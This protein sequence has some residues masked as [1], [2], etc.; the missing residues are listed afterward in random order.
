MS[1]RWQMNRMG[2]VN[3]WLYDEETFPFANG[4]LFLRGANASGKSI[5]TQSFIPFILDGDR[6]PERLDPFGS[7][8]RKMEYYFLGNDDKDDVTG[9]LFLEFKKGDTEQY[10]TIGIGQRAQ[11]GKPM[12]FWG[13]II[14]D[15]KRIEYDMNLYQ[16][17]GSK[18]IPYTK[19]DLKKI[20]G[21]DNIVLDSQTEYM[22]RVNKYIFGFPRIEQYDQFIR[23][24]IKVRAPKLSRDFKPTKVYEILNE[25]LQ[26]LSDE[27]LRAMVDA[28]E[29]MDDIQGRL[30]SLKAA[31]KDLQS[32]RT[33]YDH[34]NRYMLSKKAHTYLE[35]KKQVDVSR[36]K[37]D[38]YKDEVNTAQGDKAAK[39]HENEQLINN[40]EILENEKEVLNAND[41]ESSVEKLTRRKKEKEGF[42]KDLKDLECKIEEHRN[43]IREYY[44]NQRNYKNAVENHQYEIDKMIQELQEINEILHFPQNNILKDMIMQDD[45]RYEFTCVKNELK[46]YAVAIEKGFKALQEAAKVDDIW[47]KLEEELSTL[48]F[49]KNKSEDQLKTAEIME[50]Q[51]RDSIVEDF[52]ILSGKYQELVIAKQELDMIISCVMKYEGAKDLGEIKKIID[53]IHKSKSGK[54]LESQIECKKNREDL[55]YLNKNAI[56][57]LDKLRNMKDPIPERRDKVTKARKI[58]LEKG[59]NC[60]PFYEAVEFNDQLIDEEKS[61]LEEQLLDAGLLDALVVANKDYEKA[62]TEL[63]YLSDTLWQMDT[64]I[65]TGFNKL[66]PGELDEELRVCVEQILDSISEEHISSV[67]LI[68]RADGYFKN[69][70]IEGHSVVEGQASF[71][72][73]IARRQKMLRLIEEKEVECKRLGDDL[74]DCDLKLENIQN[75]IKVLEKE[76]DKIPQFDDLDQAIGMVQESNYILAKAYEE[77]KKMEKELVGIADRKKSCEQSVIISCKG[78]PFERK[79]EDYQGA[80]DTAENYR[81]QLIEFES[82]IGYLRTSKS[83]YNNIQDLI[84]K[85]EDAIDDKDLQLKKA[86]QVLIVCKTEIIQIEEF[87]SSPENKE[88]AEKLEKVKVEIEEKKQKKIDNGEAIAILRT[89]IETKNIDMETLNTNIIEYISYENKVRIYYQEELG[90][91]LIIKQGSRSFTECVAEAVA[92]IRENDKNKSIAEVITSLNKTFREN[93]SNLTNYGASLEDCFDD[94]LENTNLLRKRQCIVST[95]Q[96]KKLYLEEFY[97]VLKESIESTELLIQVKDRELFENILADTLSRKLSNRIAESKIWIKDMSKLMF[98]MDTSMGLTFSLDWKP[99]TADNDKELDTQEL[100]KLLSRDRDLL[101]IEDIEKVSVH[102]RSKIRLAKQIAEDNGDI[103]NYSDLVR[104]ALDYRQWFEFKM[105]FYR[106]GDSKKELTNSAFNKFSGGEKAMAMYVPLFAAVNAQYKKSENIDHPRIIALDEAFAGVDDKNISSMFELVQQLDFDYIMNSQALW[107]CYETVKSLRIAEL[108]R[109]ANSSVVTVIYYYW[110]GKERVLDE[111]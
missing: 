38:I 93:T 85:E 102:F 18:K 34:Y 99:R 41:L 43:Q 55:Y 63:C 77:Y 8:D 32:I 66:V 106:N 70:V 23:L 4:K 36:T 29:K 53:G 44:S 94:D 84:T 110:N 42:E 75:S 50:T 109:P 25:S 73:T 97:G 96:G 72:G 107:G 37:L 6:S 31:F 24:M 88:R 39:E 59:I 49:N 83:N 3:F 86:N 111:Q 33:E 48:N 26:K 56:E 64:N 61:L 95:W 17:V 19:Q 108:L 52:Y 69:G 105:Y 7:K 12:G 27:D 65:R 9:Y 82:E 21:E 30:D 92:S 57:D 51:C 81:D 101:T 5:T 79:L 1:N 28:M 91:G 40:I 10:R 14:L 67:G 71:V 62:K 20:L 104:D 54:L 46:E 68:L 58:L 60:L 89:M 90:L 35:A 13:F 11:K 103:I 16:E 74:H 2:F 78:L 47:N 76:Y 100:E 15:G 87:L 22:E 80:I 98:D 45:L